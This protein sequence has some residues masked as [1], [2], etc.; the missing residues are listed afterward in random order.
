M[1]ALLLLPRPEEVPAT[2]HFDGGARLLFSPADTRLHHRRGFSAS[3]ARGRHVLGLRYP[4]FD[5]R[6]VCNYESVQVVAVLDQLREQSHWARNQVDATTAQ[7]Y[8]MQ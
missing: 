6:H 3:E 8:V 7:L 1:G 5:R 4:G 2:E